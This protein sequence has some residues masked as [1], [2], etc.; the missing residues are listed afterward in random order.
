M[1][2]F[3]TKLVVKPSM[4]VSLSSYLFSLNTSEFIQFGALW[5][6]NHGFLSLRRETQ[7]VEDTVTREEIP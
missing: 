6:R 2:D 5:D 7:F 3:E 4:Q 1:I